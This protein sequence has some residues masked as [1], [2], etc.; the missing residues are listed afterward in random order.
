[1]KKKPVFCLILQITDFIVFITD[2]LLSLELCSSRGWA[3]NPAWKLNYRQHHIQCLGQN[4]LVLLQLRRLMRLIFCKYLIILLVLVWCEFVFH[5]L[6][7]TFFGSSGWCFGV[8]YLIYLPANLSNWQLVDGYILWSVQCFTN[9][10]F[11][12]NTPFPCS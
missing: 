7:E 2:Y 11:C 1:M 4:I 10:T 8:N 12:K 6:S 3:L 5:Q 9:R